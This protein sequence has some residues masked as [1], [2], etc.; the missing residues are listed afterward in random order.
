[1][2]TRQLFP[3]PGGDKYRFVCQGYAKVASSEQSRTRVCWGNLTGKRDAEV[4]F[5]DLEHVKQWRLGGHASTDVDKVQQLA[6]EIDIWI[7]VD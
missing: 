5:Y 1:M 4:L 7:V 2:D 3:R 6:D